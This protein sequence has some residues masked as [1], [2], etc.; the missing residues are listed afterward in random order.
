MPLPP[1]GERWQVS[2]S[3]GAQPRWSSD[4]K[5]LFFL[6]TDGRLMTVDVEARPGAPPAI[7]APRALFQ[8]GLSVTL[9]LDQFAVGRDG[10]RFL[11]RR[12]EETVAKDEIRIIVNWP[13]LLK[14]K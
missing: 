14:T 12:P 4:G 3:G 6:A 9:N 8:T 13:E 2:V 7:S 5:S 1:T 11:I 10:Q